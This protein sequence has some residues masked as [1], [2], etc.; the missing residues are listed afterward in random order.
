MKRLSRLLLSTIGGVLFIEI[1]GHWS[2]EKLKEI[3]YVK[4]I[5]IALHWFRNLTIVIEVYWIVIA[6]LV[7]FFLLRYWNELFVRFQ[8]KP[9]FYNYK[10]DKFHNWV[11]KWNYKYFKNRNRWDIVDLFPYCPKCD[12]PL[13]GAGLALD[14][15]L[16]VVEA[17][18]HNCGT[19]WNSRNNAYEDWR[20]IREI[21]EKKMELLEKEN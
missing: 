19:T 5:A 18:C 7:V 4:F 13:Y 17:K 2:Y 8:R 11:W 10:S 21:I 15:T 14:G 20:H 12:L 16:S 3:D 1:F 9:K 6:F